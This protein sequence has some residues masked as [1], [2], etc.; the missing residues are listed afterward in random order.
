MQTLIRVRRKLTLG[1][2]TL[3]TLSTT[4]LAQAAGGGSE[5]PM[6]VIGGPKPSIDVCPTDGCSARPS[7]LDTVKLTTVRQTVIGPQ[8]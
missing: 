8:Y 4:D 5:K 3:R 2:E 7:C 1:K 6:T